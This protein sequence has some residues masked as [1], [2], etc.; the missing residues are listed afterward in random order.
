MKSQADEEPEQKR[1][2][3]RELHGKAFAWGQASAGLQATDSKTGLVEQEPNT[4]ES[5]SH[6]EVSENR[7]GQG[8]ETRA[9]AQDANISA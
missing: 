6:E 8:R 5:I 4:I 2:A 9:T 7:K 3:S 1:S